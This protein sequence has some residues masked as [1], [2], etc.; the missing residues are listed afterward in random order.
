MISSRIA[1]IFGDGGD[2]AR[3]A[4]TISRALLALHATQHCNI[5]AA[6]DMQ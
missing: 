6:G 4:L 2:V 5:G 3:V 1:V